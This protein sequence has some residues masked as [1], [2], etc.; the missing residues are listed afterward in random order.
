VLQAFLTKNPKD[1]TA[2]IDLGNLYNANGQFEKARRTYEQLLAASPDSAAALNNLAYYYA[3]HGDDLNKAQGFAES[4]QELLPADPN[5]ADTLAWILYRKGDYG[6]AV[7]LLQGSASKPPVAPEILYHLGMASAM[8]GNADA[9]RTALNQAL[10]GEG[11]FEGKAS[12]PARLA[13]MDQVEAGTASPEEI[14]AFL[15][16]QP[17]D[18]Y[19]LAAL[20]DA[21]ERAGEQAKAAAAY[22]QALDRNPKLTTAAL[23][24]AELDAG[25]LHAPDKAFDLA[26]TVR[27]REPANARAAGVLGSVAYQRRDFVQA[28][29]LLQE[30][31]GAGGG[32]AGQISMLEDFAWAAYSQG[33]LADARNAM[34]RVKSAA[35][36]N[37]TEAADAGSFLSMVDLADHP[38]QLAAVESQIA[39]VLQATPDNVPALM[40]RA[41]LRMS[42]GDGKG[43]AED[44][45]A[46][47]ARFPDFPYAESG[48]ASLYL[49]DPATQDKAYDLAAKAHKALPDDP[50]ASEALAEASYQRKDYSYA[51][52]LLQEC[53]Q[54]GPLGNEPLYYLGMALWQTKQSAESRQTLDQAVSAGLSGA[55]LAEAQQVLHKLGEK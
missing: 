1:P 10:A 32:D 35:A 12:I 36:A 21:W 4:A 42:R 52:Q 16:P 27:E 48:L 43:A 18:V 38:G 31:I 14:E 39:K 50:K 24:L 53:A 3:E 11:D 6:R 49:M 23:G 13:F 8:M 28:Y 20:G 47:L 34:Q 33:N 9:A 51:V 15:K 5:I 55:H 40:A 29:A 41:R 37:S 46:A 26:K 45:A 19:A 54:A 7:G 22:Q 2:L 30:A 44:Y 25:P 17:T